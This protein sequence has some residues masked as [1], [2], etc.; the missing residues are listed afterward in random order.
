MM[1]ALKGNQKAGLGLQAAAELVPTLRVRST[2]SQTAEATDESTRCEGHLPCEGH[3]GRQNRASLRGSPRQE[4][5]EPCCAVCV[6]ACL[7][8]CVCVCMSAS[9]CM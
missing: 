8:K 1:G 9:V 6:C 2:H 3:E 7:C 4:R 5:T